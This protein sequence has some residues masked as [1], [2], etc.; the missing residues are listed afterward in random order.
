MIHRITTNGMMNSYKFNLMKSYNSLAS[1]S[2][3][4]TTERKF[5]SYAEDPTKASQA[6]QLR[7]SRWNTENQIANSKQV[8]HK[9]QQAWDCLST[10]YDDLGNKLARFSA[11]RADNAADHPG[12]PSLGEVILGAA[13]S[14]METMNGKYGDNFV[15]SGADGQNVPFSMDDDGNVYYRGYNVK[16]GENADGDKVDFQDIID[17]E[18][19]Y[20][21][22]GMGMKEDNN[23]ELIP[24]SAFDTALQGVDFIGFGT[25]PVTLN[26][27]TSVTVPN[28]VIS[29]MHEMGKLYASCSPDNGAYPD[30]VNFG[31]NYGTN[32]GLTGDQW[33]EALETKLKDA[34]NDVHA[35]W[36]SL[37]TDA[38]YL[39]SNEE[40]L[41]SLDD[42]LNEQIVDIEDIDPADAITSLMWAQYSYNAALRIGM[43][44][45]SQSLIDYMN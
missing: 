29:I 11:L 10:T 2:E 30:D 21:D 33:A 36:M 43:N 37:D 9:F 12:R 4:V 45:L 34:L 35:K 23:G 17:K 14:V 39:K 41:T 44:I 20:V 27:G 6:F 25:S 5:N 38:T 28:N 42:S 18:H 8:T 26:D 19:T 1:A 3:K 40:R 13:K 31:E 7:R 15:F 16:T 22:L 32:S 24:S